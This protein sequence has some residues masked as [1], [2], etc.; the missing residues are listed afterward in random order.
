M[1][2]PK[3]GEWATNALRNFRTPLQRDGLGGGVIVREGKHVKEQLLKRIY[4]FIF[5]CAM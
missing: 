3:A 5:V 2:M 1:Q 4:R